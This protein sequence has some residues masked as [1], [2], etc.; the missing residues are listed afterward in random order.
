[1]A[2]KPE[3]NAEHAMERDEEIELMQRTGQGDAQ[4]YRALADHFLPRIV[5]YCTRLLGNPTEAEDV[6]QETFLR[7]WKQADRWKPD[8]RLS[9]WLFRIA[10]NRCIDRLRK[11]RESSPDHLDRQSIGD[12]PSALMLRKQIASAVELAL[13]ELPE[14]QR[15]AI[16]LSH[17]E[18]LSNP[19]IAEVLD[20]SVEA[21]ESLLSRGRRTLRRELASLHAHLQGQDR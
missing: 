17:Y 19:E 5:A 15:A 18:G 10:H 16:S 3:R 11:R 13:S 2:P 12:R 8:A 9:T 7:L 4:A 20:V 14:R 1:V 21:V 6:A